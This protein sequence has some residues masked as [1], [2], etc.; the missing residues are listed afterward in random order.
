MCM[1]SSSVR[2][3]MWNVWCVNFSW[4]F[5]CSNVPFEF[6]VRAYALKNKTKQNKTIITINEGKAIFLIAVLKILQ[7]KNLLTLMIHRTC[8]NFLDWCWYFFWTCA[9]WAIRTEQTNNLR[10]SQNIQLNAA[11]NAV[12]RLPKKSESICLTSIW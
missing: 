1:R 6:V 5:C 8:F 10:W 9:L 2:D 11:W 3:H 7:F 4:I 12:I